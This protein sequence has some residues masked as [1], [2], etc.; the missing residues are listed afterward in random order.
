[1]SEGFDDLGGIEW[2]PGLDEASSSPSR[3]LATAYCGV[4]GCGK[5]LGFTV[6]AYSDLH[7]LVGI[8]RGHPNNIT[9]ELDRRYLDRKRT[10]A[11]NAGQRF[12]HGLARVRIVLEGVAGRPVV[13]TPLI[14]AA[15]PAEF[16]EEW[17]DWLATV[18]NPR[19]ETHVYTDCG[20]HLSVILVEDAH[21]AVHS[22]KLVSRPVVTP[23]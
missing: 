21:R 12:D 14:R 11:K 19:W 8:R 4:S 22:G 2:M 18:E 7:M 16:H 15:V 13:A 20:A 23:E 1:M 3:T 9:N 5:K 10:H 17:A 6:E